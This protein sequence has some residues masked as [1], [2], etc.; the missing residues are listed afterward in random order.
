[1]VVITK[2]CTY[3]LM[4][5][6]SYESYCLQWLLMLFSTVLSSQSPFAWP[7]QVLPG[8]TQLHGSG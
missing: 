4:F 6:Y 3:V 7:L 8:A 1:M 5:E 2:Y